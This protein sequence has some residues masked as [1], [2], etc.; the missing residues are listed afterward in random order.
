MKKK[1]LGLQQRNGYENVLK[2]IR[3][4]KRLNHQ[5]IISLYE[6]INDD[7]SD[8]IY[9]IL[10]Y[11]SGGSLMAKSSFTEEEL[12]RYFINIVEGLD[13]CM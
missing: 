4:L 11:V 1:R 10:E 13:Y 5:N 3:I 8:H 6:V 12:K 7:H 2:E 9:L